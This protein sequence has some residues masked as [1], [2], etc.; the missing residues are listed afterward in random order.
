MIILKGKFCP[1]TDKIGQRCKVTW[2][3]KTKYYPWNYSKDEKQNFILAFQE[4]SQYF[5]LWGE[6][7]YG[8]DEQLG[9]F[10][11]VQVDKQ[12]MFWGQGNGL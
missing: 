1:P 8:Y 12:N 3:K 2:N 9:L 11:G 4:Y 6:F 5:N 7:L 10:L